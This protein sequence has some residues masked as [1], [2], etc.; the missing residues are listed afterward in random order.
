[1]RKLETKLGVFTKCVRFDDAFNL[2]AREKVQVLKFL[3]LQPVMW[4]NVTCEHGIMDFSFNGIWYTLNN[5]NSDSEELL[6]T[7]YKL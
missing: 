5:F 7:N 6:L 2:S 3:E 1:M 4:N